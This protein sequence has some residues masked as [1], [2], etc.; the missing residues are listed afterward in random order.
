MQTNVHGLVPFFEIAG[1]I[2]YNF[3]DKEDL[4]RFNSIK[5]SDSDLWKGDTK[6][7][8]DRWD[9]WKERLRWISEQSELKQRTRDEAR[10]LVQLLQN[11]EERKT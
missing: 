2:I 6:F 3:I 4:S 1:D 11:I 10:M 9:F 8:K 7:T 5:H